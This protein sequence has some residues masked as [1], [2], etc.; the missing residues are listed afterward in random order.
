[1]KTKMIG[2]IFPGN[3][4]RKISRGGAKNEGL[5]SYGWEHNY[6]IIDTFNFSFFKFIGSSSQIK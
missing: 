1:V 4:E 6:R 2:K 5:W 3:G